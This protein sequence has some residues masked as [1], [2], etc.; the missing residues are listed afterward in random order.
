MPRAN[1]QRERVNRTLI[2]LLT[3]LA[4][5]KP[6]EWHKY[7]ESAQKYLNATP[8]KNTN[9]TPFRLLFGTH[10]RMRGDP[11][12]RKLIEDEWI[13]MFQ[14]QR[15]EMRVRAKGKIAEVQDQNRKSFDKNRKEATEYRQGQLIA[16]KRTQAGPGLKFHAKYFGPY[17]IRRVLRNNRYVVEKVGEHEG[18]RTTSTATDHM[19]PWVTDEEDDLSE[20]NETM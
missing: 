9:T 5:P 14:E 6:E 16:I 1:G 11:E 7:L 13:S 8:S 12:V 4:A 17:C 2:S 20:D 19:K 15:D 3:K 10:I 18:P